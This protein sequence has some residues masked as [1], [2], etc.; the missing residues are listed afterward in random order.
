MNLEELAIYIKENDLNSTVRERK[1][2]HIR[3]YLYHILKRDTLLTLQEI[4][5]IFNRNHATIINGLKIYDLYGKHQDFKIDIAVVKVIIPRITYNLNL[6]TLE[7]LMEKRK[8]LVNDIKSLDEQI[9]K[10]EVS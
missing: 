8:I 1:L 4:G 3:A 9:L 5:D 2:V 7:A 6:K 10:L